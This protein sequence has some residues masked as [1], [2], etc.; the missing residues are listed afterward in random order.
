MLHLIFE[1]GIMNLQEL[2]LMNIPK[3]RE[4]SMKTE[5]LSI[6][7]DGF[8]NLKFSTID[9]GKIVAL[10]S[11]NGYGKSNM[12]QAIDFVLDFIHFDRDGKSHM[13]G[14]VRGIPLNQYSASRNFYA[15]LL[16]RIKSEGRNELVKYGFQFVW[17][18]NDKSGKRIVKEWLYKKEEKSRARYNQLLFRD[19]EGCYY[20]SSETGRCSTPLH[21]EDDELGINKL[22]QMEVLWLHEAV[23]AVND[24]SVYIDRHLDVSNSYDR[25]PVLINKKM[26]NEFALEEIQNIPRAIYFL[27]ERNPDKFDRLIDAFFQLFPNIESMNVREFDLAPE[28]QQKLPDDVPFTVSNKIYRLYYKDKNLNQFLDFDLLSDGTKRIFLTLTYI[29]IADINNTTLIA[30]EEPEN[31]IHPGL[32]QN[33]LDVVSQLSKNCKV[34]VSSHSPY[35]LQYIDTSSIYVGRPNSEGLARFCRFAPQKLN[36]LERDA[37]DSDISVGGYIFELLSGSDADEDI[38]KGYLED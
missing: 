11:Q 16:I 24:C 21:L 13:M 5:L 25:F 8:K 29:T 7:I 36:S 35:I 10:V 23:K 6:T 17:A 37:E 27:K 26:T 19:Q 34:L 20:R 31:S 14:W 3:E 18:K 2:L 28:N 38:L 4:N 1:G 32:L 9:F 15:E 30:F 12:L 22:Q 33:F